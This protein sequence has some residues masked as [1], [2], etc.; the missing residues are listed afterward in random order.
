M[1]NTGFP[2]ISILLLEEKYRVLLTENSHLSDASS[3]PLN[4]FD[5]SNQEDAAWVILAKMHLHKGR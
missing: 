4:L 2:E 5:D 3:S 1:S